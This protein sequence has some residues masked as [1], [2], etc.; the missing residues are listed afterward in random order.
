MRAQSFALGKGGGGCHDSATIP[1]TLQTIFY[2]ENSSD[3]AMHASN[4]SCILHD[5]IR[6]TSN[7][8]HIIYSEEIDGKRLSA[9]LCECDAEEANCAIRRKMYAAEETP[10]CPSVKNSSSAGSRNTY[11]HRHRFCTLVASKITPATPTF[12]KLS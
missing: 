10:F 5:Q 4:I 3:L 1:A 11:V 8:C 2:H 9:G 6:R 12:C 7:R